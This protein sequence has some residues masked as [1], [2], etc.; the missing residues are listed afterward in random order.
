M[1]FGAIG[2]AVAGTAIVGAAT[3]IAAI[4]VGVITAAVVGAAIGGLTAA[5]TGG[6]VGKGMLFGAIGGVVSAG[7]SGVFAGAGVGVEQTASGAFLA[8]GGA[9][10]GQVIA[11]KTIETGSST[12][13][14]SLAEVGKKIATQ[15]GGEVVKSGISGYMANEGQKD[16]IKA[17]REAAELKH[18]R[19]MEIIDLQAKHSKELSAMGGSGGA[20]ADNTGH[21]LTYDA[22]MA[23][24]AQRSKE[25]DTTTKQQRLE[26]DTG[27]QRIAT[28]Q[29]LFALKGGK[30]AN[31]VDQYAGQGVQGKRQMRNI[32]DIQALS[33]PVAV[34]EEEVA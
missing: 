18:K 10:G 33:G 26:W 3:S 22:R 14:A 31:G 21:Q 9:A 5:I 16:M 19:D 17:N 29:G 24:L 8:D 23:E 13:G 28:R 25:F 2:V 34:P 4:T 30:E 1:G 12:I 15:V 6:S 11:T 27:Q 20:G 7:L 32:E